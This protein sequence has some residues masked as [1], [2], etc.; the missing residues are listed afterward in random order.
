MDIGQEEESF[1]AEPV[2]DP[3]SREIPAPPDRDVSPIEV[4]EEPL[5]PA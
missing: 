2:E 5:V 4:T 3:F 1:V